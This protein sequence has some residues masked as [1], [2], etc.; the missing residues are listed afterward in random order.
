[1]HATYHGT[2][3][4]ILLKSPLGARLSVAVSVHHD[5]LQLLLF[6]L[7]GTH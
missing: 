7:P 1:M 5:C 2:D 4:I 6:D 3:V